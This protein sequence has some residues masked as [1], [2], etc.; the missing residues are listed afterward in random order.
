MWD[1]M[2]WR[3][4]SVHREFFLANPRL[5][6]LVTAFEQMD[7]AKRRAYILRGEAFLESLGPGEGRSP[8]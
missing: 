5:S 4:I 3:F 1:A 6:V 8:S 2:F 7:A